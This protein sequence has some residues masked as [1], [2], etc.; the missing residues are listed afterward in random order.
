VDG[1]S[2][3]R[4]AQA[5]G[6]SVVADGAQLRVRGPRSAGELARRLLAH[7]AAVLAAL[8]PAPPPPGAVTWEQEH[9]LEVEALRAKAAGCPDP[10]WAGVLL[11]LAAEPETTL[12]EHMAWGERLL[13]ACTERT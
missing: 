1:L 4:E 12:A 13:M 2:L 9:E 5:A 10:W 11:A 6:L 3:L 8:R 7:K